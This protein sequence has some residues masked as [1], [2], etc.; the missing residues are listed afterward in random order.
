MSEIPLEFL[1]LSNDEKTCRSAGMIV[2]NP[3]GEILL[4]D[5]RNGVL[6]WACPAGHVE[7]EEGTLDCAL[8]ELTEETGIQLELKNVTDLFLEQYIN[9]SC[10][11]G[12]SGHNW[13]IYIA[14]TP[15]D[16]IIL[17]EPDDH[18]GIGWFKLEELEYLQLEPVW[19]II[20]DRYK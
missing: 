18:K 12:A 6:G 11:R 10:N 3:D 5:R 1:P 15:N 20:L 16:R 8:R 14:N 19:K 2:R 7:S 9:N 17:K 4:L 13:T